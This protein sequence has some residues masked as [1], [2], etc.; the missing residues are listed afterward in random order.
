MLI[1]KKLNFL[2]VGESWL[3]S[4][5][6][7]LKEYLLVDPLV[8]LDEISEDHYK[9]IASTFIMRLANRLLNGIY[10]R[11]LNRDV[12]NK[13]MIIRPNVLLI[14]KGTLVNKTTIDFAK[15][16]GVTTVNIFPDCS[17]HAHGSQLKEAMGAYD[18]IIS[19]KPFHPK[20]W[21][22]IYGYKNL[23][24][25][26]P[27]GFDGKLYSKIDFSIKKDFDV[28]M[29]ASWR[30]EYEKLMIELAKI[31]G[32]ESISVLIAGPGWEKSRDKLPMHWRLL[33]PVHG[34]AYIETIQRGRIII[35]PVQT[36][37]YVKGR[38]QPGDED[39]KRSYEL[40]A[41]KAF[42]VHRRTEY[43]QTVYSEDEEV[44]MWNDAAELAKIICKY[45]PLESDRARMASAA[46]QRAMQNFCFSSRAVEIIDQISRILPN[47]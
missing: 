33:G 5:A 47:D 36:E 21:S 28:V 2:F 31:I 39:S 16:I 38:K 3:G 6:R 41:A 23:C 24:I 35:A 43:I 11:N 32:S 37:M 4:S 7:S 46:N 40:A 27:H 15:S 26:I 8:N 18:L 25:S 44:P 10:V 17:P 13:L 45:L 29:I 14:Y 19:T 34:N 20:F 42:F 22:S 1:R 9:P 12:K 30:N